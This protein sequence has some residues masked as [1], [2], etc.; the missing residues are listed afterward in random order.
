MW[1]RKR[2]KARDTHTDLADAQKSLEQARADR[3]RQQVKRYAEQQDVIKKFSGFE[4]HNNIAALIRRAL[5]Q[6]GEEAR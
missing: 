1:L 2:A 5:Q 3:S 4:Q 6:H